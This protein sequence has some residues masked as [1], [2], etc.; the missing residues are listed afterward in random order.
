MEFTT[1]H[2]NVTLALT[3]L[4]QN[5][6][7]LVLTGRLLLLNAIEFTAFDCNSTIRIRYIYRCNTR[8]LSLKSICV[9]VISLQ[10]STF[11]DSNSSL[12][13]TPCPNCSKLHVVCCTCRSNCSV[14]DNNITFFYKYNSIVV[15]TKI[16]I[17]HRKSLTTQI[18]CYILF[19]SDCIG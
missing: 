18:K 17:N 14:F 1:L 3:I 6:Q 2:D 4:F 10:G 19:N 7:N 5:I 16:V 13:W 15:L 8:I 9:P 11:L 12:F